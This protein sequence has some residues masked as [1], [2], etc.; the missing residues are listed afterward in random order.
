M[1]QQSN[2]DVPEESDTPVRAPW[3]R[4][5]GD[6][7]SF[8][9]WLRQQREIRGLSLRE[10]VDSTK[11][12]MRYLE[13]LESDRFERLP[14]PIFAR[15][16]LRQYAQYVG[17]DSDEVVNFYLQVSEERAD[18]ELESPG[19]ELPRTRE[20]GR[21]LRVAFVLLVLVGVVLLGLGIYFF[22]LQVRD[23]GVRDEMGPD[24]ET[25]PMAAPVPR[26][27]PEEVSEPG[28]V[29]PPDEQDLEVTLV[30]TGECWVE[31][32]VDGERILSELRVQ[33]E[34]IQLEA[35][36]RIELTLGEPANVRVEV[37]DRPFDLDVPSGRVA[38]GI[39]IGRE[40]AGLPP[41][42]GEEDR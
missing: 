17:L 16:F 31:A 38:R 25:P 15:G 34:S 29:A 32:R 40:D 26:A 23:P 21:W 13:A 5:G 4:E 10:I 9:E 28:V 1:P 42:P 24:P 35:E 19:A 7:T 12:S 14:A 39:V 30:F 41:L 6:A 3:N 2:R 37:N 8:G 20:G 22:A 27:V 36:R 11:I 33:G 18:E